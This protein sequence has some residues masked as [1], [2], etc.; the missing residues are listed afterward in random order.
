MLKNLF[1][2]KKNPS[3]VFWIALPVFLIGVLLLGLRAYL[4][5][6]ANGDLVYTWILLGGFAFLILALT[7]AYKMHMK[8]SKDVWL[9]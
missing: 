8:R 4:E 6:K 1:D 3:S 7:P 5:Y 2:W 9:K